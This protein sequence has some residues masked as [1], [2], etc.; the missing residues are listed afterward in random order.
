M[1]RDVTIL[2]IEA[3]D[4]STLLKITNVDTPD[5]VWHGLTARMNIKAQRNGRGLESVVTRRACLLFIAVAPRC[6]G[7]NYRQ[8]IVGSD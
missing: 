5:N 6:S 2:L 7:S 4:V 3:Q 1:I 8:A